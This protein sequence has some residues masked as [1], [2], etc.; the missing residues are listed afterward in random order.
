MYWR[1]KESYTLILCKDRPARN[2]QYRQNIVHK[3]RS[4]GV[5]VKPGLTENQN[6]NCHSEKGD[7]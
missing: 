5:E 6:I 1:Y 4:H 3:H 7:S 2:R